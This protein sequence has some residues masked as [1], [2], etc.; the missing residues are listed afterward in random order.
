MMRLW[1]IDFNNKKIFFFN[2]FDIKRQNTYIFLTQ[3][4]KICLCLL[5]QY[6]ILPKDLNF[7]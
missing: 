4:R 3:N 2:R 7:F 5:I 6:L 1:T